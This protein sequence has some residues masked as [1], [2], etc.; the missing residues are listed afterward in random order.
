MTAPRLLAI[1]L[2]AALA[3]AGGAAIHVAGAANMTVQQVTLAIARATPGHPADLSGKDLS[4]LD[5]SDIDFK[6]AKL[7]GTSLYTT[8]LTDSNLA[9][10]D[11]AGVDLSHAIII[12]TNFAGARLTNITMIVPVPYSTFEVNPAE[13]PNFAGADLSGARILARLNQVNLREARLAG[14]KIVFDRRLVS[15]RDRPCDFTGSDMR[16]A[17]LTGADFRKTTLDFVKF[18]GARL[19][20]ADLR[21]AELIGADLRGADLTGADLAGADLEDARLAGVKGLARAKGL[22]QARNRDKAIY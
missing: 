16:D 10:A 13:V 14:V 11:L 15:A 1:L 2:L 17:D 3:T 18:Q 22:A 12:R 8:D 19:V 7:A 4:G 9:G 20:D 5:L 21:G 6:G